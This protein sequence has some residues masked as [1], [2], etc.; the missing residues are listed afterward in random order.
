[1]CIV[2]FLTEFDRASIPMR[3]FDR[4]S[5]PSIS[6]NLNAQIRPSIN[7]NGFP[8]QNYLHVL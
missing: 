8:P 4:T 1:M 3:K 5:I 2:S 7:A 6:R